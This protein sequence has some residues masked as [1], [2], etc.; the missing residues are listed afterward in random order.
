MIRDEELNR[1]IRYAQGMGISVRFKPYV[2]RSK[3]AAEWTI[4]GSEIT[5]YVTSTCS[6]LY[7][8][9]SLIHELGHH[10][11]FV[12]NN[13]VMDP[14]L[15]AALGNEDNLKRNSKRLLDMETVDSSYWEEIYRD[16]NCQFGVE[17][18]R[19]QREFDLWTYEFNYE[20]GRDPTKKEKMAKM[21]ELKR[22]NYE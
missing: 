7:K 9:L 22:K 16:T 21:K 3:V 19:R 14:K 10:K 5:I 12:D 11:G 17:K 13:R 4:D 20:M 8:I 18:L 1:L 2:A 6:K 15:E